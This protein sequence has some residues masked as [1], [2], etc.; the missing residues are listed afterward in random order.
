MPGL[1]SSVPQA[2][3]LSAALPASSL[4]NVFLTHHCDELTYLGNIFIILLSS[5]EERCNVNIK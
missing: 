2:A 1:L 4:S 5:L 3:L